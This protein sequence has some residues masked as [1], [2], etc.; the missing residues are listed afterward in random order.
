MQGVTSANQQVKLETK[1]DF[2]TNKMEN[3]TGYLCLPNLAFFF[4]ASK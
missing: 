1:G 4:H 2:S 3:D